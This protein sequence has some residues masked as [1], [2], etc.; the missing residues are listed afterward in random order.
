MRECGAK[1]RCWTRLPIARFVPWFG[2][3]DHL[4]F[5]EGAIG[6]P[7]VAMINWDDEFIHSS[8]DDLN[9][10][11][12]TQLRRNNFLIGSIAYFLIRAKDSDVPVIAAETYAQGANRLANDLKVAMRLLKSSGGDAGA[13]WKL[14]GMMIEAGI[15]REVRALE[16][17][18]VFGDGNS[19]AAQTIAELVKA[20]NEK[21]AAL[22]S[23]LTTFYRQLHGSDPKPVAL[24]A[25]EL[26]AS[27]KIPANTA[28]LD[29]YFDNR[30]KIRVRTNL[31]G[32]MR[33]EVFN[34]VDGKRS[35]YD[36]YK[37]VYAESQAAGSWY[38][39]NVTLKDVMT[40]LD[41]AVESKAL[42]SK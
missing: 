26:A 11:D 2:S 7:A 35:Y 5:L 17:A 18:R 41:E 22:M 36:I 33:D 20:T 13:G 15:A 29:T 25:E 24:A 37:A 32:L 27:K 38:Y 12:Q 19:K 10:I 34:F 1:M 3:S 8:D 14:A 6:I 16:S 4:V 9:Q 23:E 31:H 39:G 42:T 30:R 21:R 40:L 28:N